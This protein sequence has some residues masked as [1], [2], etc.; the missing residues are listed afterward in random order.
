MRR[1]YVDFEN[2]KSDGL[3]GIGSLTENDV[4]S[5]LFSCNAD[6]VKMH[7]VKQILR[8]KASIEA[9]EAE[10]GIKNALDFQLLAYLSC[11]YS[12][13]D[14]FYIVSND[15]GYDKFIKTFIGRSGTENIFRM[16]SISKIYSPQFA[17]TVLDKTD[18]LREEVSQIL[19][20]KCS[21]ISYTNYIDVIV[22]GIN[23]SE[24]ITKFYYACKKAIHD[25][26]DLK[27]VYWSLRDRFT[28]LKQLGISRKEGKKNEERMEV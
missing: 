14:Y 15:T 9:I 23:E 25:N 24:N 1:F 26:V 20:E 13:K 28:E 5:I 4:V 8:S 21:E 6:S 17:I 10:V 12:T 19:E 18:D 16:S 7:T 27:K 11:D 22:N 3:K 2:V